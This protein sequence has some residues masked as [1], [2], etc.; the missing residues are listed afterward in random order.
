MNKK[1]LLLL[2]PNLNMVGV[3]EKGIYGEETAESIAKDIEKYAANHNIDIKI[4]QSNY[5]GA[6]I[7]EIHASIGNYDAAVINPGALTH[8]SYSLRDAI[9][10]VSVPYIEVHMSN[11]HQREEFRHKSVTAPV[12]IG[13]IAGFGKYGYFMALDYI[14]N[15]L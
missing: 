3:R 9:G 13:Q 8:Y 12:C 10:G 5:E 1:V 6:L 4:F 11:I 7:D 2:G 15:N 14:N